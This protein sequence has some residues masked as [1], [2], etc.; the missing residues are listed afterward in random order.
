[1]GMDFGNFHETGFLGEKVPAM[2]NR[3]M[4]HGNRAE[5]MSDYVAHLQLHMALQARKLVPTLSER[6]EPLPLDGHRHRLLHQT[7]ARVEKLVSRQ[8]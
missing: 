8:G 7:Q 6:M 5:A 2:R 4:N 1:M 3:E